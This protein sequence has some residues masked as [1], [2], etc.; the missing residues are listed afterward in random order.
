MISGRDALGYIDQA[1]QEEQGRLTAV[2]DRISDVSDRL[3][4]LQRQTV[5]DYRALAR[6]RVDMIATGDP[7]S[8]IDAADRQVA[9][10]LGVREQA[11]SD[12][13]RGLTAARQALQELETERARQADQTDNASD[14]VDEAEAAT[15]AR[16]D[17]IADYR[18]QRDR[19]QEADRIARHAEDKAVHSEQEQEKKGDSYRED[20]MFMYLWDRGYGTTEYEGGRLTRWLD[21]RVARLIGFEDARANYH[22]LR[23][24][25]L[26]LREHA[27]ARRVEAEAQ[28][29]ALRAMDEAARGEDGVDALEQ[30]LAEEQDRLEAIDARI[31]QAESELLALQAQ[32][33]TF[34][35]GEDQHYRAA[36]QYLASEFS[37]D[38]LQSLRRDAMAT[39]F[40]EDDLI[41]TGLARREDED[42][43]LEATRRELHDAVER[44][45]QR[46]QELE[47][48]RLDF[49]RQRFDR[50]GSTF[51]DGSLVAL[52]L[53]NFLSGM[54]DRNNLW[55]VLREQQRYRP[56]RSNPTFGSGGFGRGT[57]WG[58]GGWRGGSGGGPRSGGLGGGGGG[59]FR[60]GGGF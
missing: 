24:I 44:H 45:R 57:P 43:S 25:P 39:P 15:Q 3:I 14:R 23:E 40:P 33:Q 59:G 49:R 22:R 17:Q 30:T 58:G 31:E 9:Q 32:Q 27:D 54:L 50:S 20:P 36:V 26:R 8:R 47:S 35:A 41:V 12:L 4:A 60:T 53:T 46:L 19:A 2:E 5:E 13:D 34:A 38:D 10:M 1:R 21:G 18:A 37:H 51:S 55:R 11:A 16:L 28:F 7:I 42:Q 29:D 56:R 6:L 48:L 52:M